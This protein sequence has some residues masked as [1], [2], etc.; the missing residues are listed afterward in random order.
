MP[1][2]G[3]HRERTEGRYPLTSQT[4]PDDC[5]PQQYSHKPSA[6]SHHVPLRRTREDC[7]ANTRASRTLSIVLLCIRHFPPSTAIHSDQ[8]P[9]LQCVATSLRYLLYPHLHSPTLRCANH[10]LPAGWFASLRHFH[11]ARILPPAHEPSI[12]EAGGGIDEGGHYLCWRRR[13]MVGT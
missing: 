9:P 13:G 8:P 4:S 2:A 11:S 3:P 5:G 10:H 1:G 12:S 7:R 6:T